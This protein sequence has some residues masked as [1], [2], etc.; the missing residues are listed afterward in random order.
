MA[1][2]SACA[3]GA[4][5]FQLCWWGAGLLARAFTCVHGRLAT[6]VGTVPGLF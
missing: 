6:G 2:S 3:T 5:A 1:V 4:H